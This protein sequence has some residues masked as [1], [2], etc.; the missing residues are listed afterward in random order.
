MHAHGG[1]AFSTC[2]RPDA[3]G[4]R[5]HAPG[6]A[7]R[8]PR[9]P[10]TASAAGSCVRRDRRGGE[11]VLDQPGQV[12]CPVHDDAEG[13]ARFSG[14]MESPRSRSI[15]AYPL[16]GVSGVRSS[17]ETVAMKSFFIRWTCRS[18]E[19][20]RT[21]ITSLTSTSPSNT[22]RARTAWRAAP[23]GAR[24]L[25]IHRAVRQRGRT[26]AAAPSANGSTRRPSSSSRPPRR[27]DPLADR[28]SRRHPG[29]TGHGGAPHLDLPCPA[30]TMIPSL[31][32]STTARSL[33]VSSTRRTMCSAF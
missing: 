4:S 2:R 13:A 6:P 16:I 25:G 5:S 28:A 10:S 14:V 33:L 1:P 17:C 15:A 18:A 12:V 21:M 30:S 8:G 3:S 26:S 23:V 20:S 31:A 7:R 19:R 11:Q 27:P 32:W 29:D 22:P 24:Q 9:R